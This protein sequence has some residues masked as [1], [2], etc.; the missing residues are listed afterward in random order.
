IASSVNGLRRLRRFVC[1]QS[2]MENN[3]SGMTECGVIEKSRNAMLDKEF[4]CV[5]S[6]IMDHQVLG[7]SS[8]NETN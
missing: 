8:V 5:L 7:V 4:L 2:K 6:L 3:R 1:C